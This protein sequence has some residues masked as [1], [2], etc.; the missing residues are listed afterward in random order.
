[1]Q[2]DELIDALRGFALFGIL[3]VNIQCF[4]G[5]LNAPSLGVLD[6]QSSVADHV[7]VFLTALLLEFKFYPIFS[8][9]FGYGFAVQT[10]R[11]MAHGDAAGPRFLRRMNAMLLLGI[12]H[13][14]LLWFGDILTRYAATGYLLKRYAGAGPKSLLKAVRLWLAVAIVI[15]A[16]LTLS[17]IAGSGSEEPAGLN[18]TAQQTSRSA[19]SALQAYAQGN[20][21]DA[22]IQRVSDYVTV[23][24]YFVVLVPQFMVLFLLGAL[25]AQ[26]GLLRRPA[27]HR[28]LWRKLFGYGLVLGLPLN[29]LYAWLQWQASQHPWAPSAHPMLAMIT[30]ELAPILSIVFVA[31][32]ALHGHTRAGKNVVRLL[33]PAGRVALTMYISESLL[34]ALWLNGFGFGAGIGARP[35]ELLLGAAG[36]YAMLIAASHA[37]H[38]YRVAGPLEVLWRRYTYASGTAVTSRP[39]QSG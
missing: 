7:T 37:M 39:S 34:M 3:A 22:T 24:L 8:F 11:W 32:F 26:L 2:R 18:E 36:I 23:S 19:A 21:L 4:V 29:A 6:A 38:R 25:A 31:A 30:G 27:R 12:L 15:Q 14:T 17:I 16:F 33:A 35:A 9:C 5:G 13:G 20:Y 1:M 10:R 28:L